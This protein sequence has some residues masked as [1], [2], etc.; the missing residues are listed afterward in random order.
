MDYQNRYRNCGVFKQKKIKKALYKQFQ[1]KLQRGLDN[2]CLTPHCLSLISKKEWT[3]H[4]DNS[5]IL[6]SPFYGTTTNKN[7]ISYKE[8]SFGKNIKQIN[9]KSIKDGHCTHFDQ[10]K[11]TEMVGGYVFIVCDVHEIMHASPDV[12]I[13]NSQI[14]QRAN[15][16]K[17]ND[18]PFVLLCLA[19][20]QCK[21]ASMRKEWG[22]I[23]HEFGSYS[24]HNVISRK[25]QHFNSL[26]Y[27]Y[28]FGNKAA[29]DIKENS[30]VSQYVYKRFTN[31]KK[32]DTSR[33]IATKL[34]ELCANDLSFAISSL[35]KVFP[36]VHRVISPILRTCYDLQATNGKLKNFERTRSY[37]NGLWQSAL[38]F[39]A[40]TKVFHTENDCTYTVISVPKQSKTTSLA[41]AEYNF[42]FKFQDRQILGINMLPGVSFIFSGKFMTHKR[43]CNVDVHPRD[44]CFVN[45]GSYGNERLY[46]HIRKSFTRNKHNTQVN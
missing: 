4:K 3:R 39:N 20:F 37:N 40:Q 7:E 22:I 18:S 14:H 5:I 19:V 27:N 17:N 1:I 9:K 38:C 30:S 35:S 42:L 15:Y 45:F 29:Y 33:C 10:I 44:N 31:A 25:G 34:E 24:K 6:S 43:Y 13:L 16:D 41:N 2:K 21:L 23:D 11:L 26:G 46:R 36:T 12:F 32:T 8:I 28:S